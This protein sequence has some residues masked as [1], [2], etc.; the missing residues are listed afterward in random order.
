M[1]KNRKKTRYRRGRRKKGNWFTRI[2]LWQRILFCIIILLVCLGGGV[3]S[4]IAIKWNKVH[5]EDIKTEDIVINPEI[6]EKRDLDLGEGYTNIALFGV[7][8]RDGNL[9]EGNRT[10]CIIIASLNN[11]TKEIKMV[12]VYRDTLLD[13]S[14]GTYQKCNAAYSFGGPTLAINMLNMNL[15]LDIQDY[16]TVDFGAISDVIDAIGGIEIDVTDEEVEYLNYYLA[17]TAESAGKEAHFLDAGGMLLLDGPQATTYARIRS[18]AGGDFT[19]TERQRLVI[20]KIVEKLKRVNVATLNKIIDQVFPQVSTSFTL[21]ELMNYAI[22]YKDYV[23]LENT[24]FPFDTAFDSVPGAGSVVVPCDLASNVVKLHEFLFGVTEYTP[25]ST[26]YTLSGN[27]SSMVNGGGS[28]YSETYDSGYVEYAED[29]YTEEQ[30]YEEPTEQS[31]EN[32]NSGDDMNTGTN[33]ET[34]GTETE[35]IG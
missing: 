14:E 5:T 31:E 11:E 35:T 22:A 17:E 12:S 20:E 25:S 16:V 21:A 30:S 3:A 23:L 1:E 7:D 26:V 29:T 8:S 28:T 4:Y 19:R 34:T 15:D 6:R 27:I 24:G 32:E 13:L 2:K 9:G 18:T 10:D 33:Q